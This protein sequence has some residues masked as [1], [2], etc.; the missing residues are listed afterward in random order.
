[1]SISIYLAGPLFTEAEREWM[2]RLKGRIEALALEIGV[3]VEAIWPWELFAEGEIAAMGCNAIDAIFARCKN[4]LDKV[5]LVV[6]LLDGPMVDDGTAWEIG[7]FYCLH[8]D[9]S[10]IIGIRT[11]HRNGGECDGARV[12]A[13]IQGCC[14]RIASSADELLALLRDIFLRL[15][16]KTI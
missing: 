13:M 2:S 14:S 7:Y 5:D 10:R 8:A 6:P 1:M 4:A 3:A 12:N 9:K 11:D 16:E 15:S